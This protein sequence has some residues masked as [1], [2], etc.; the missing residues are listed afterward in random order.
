MTEDLLLNHR[1]IKNYLRKL[2]ST[3][4]DENNLRKLLYKLF[5]YD[6]NDI[7]ISIIKNEN[8][9]DLNSFPKIFNTV[10]RTDIINI[11]NNEVKSNYYEKIQI[12]DENDLDIY[13][14]N[15]NNLLEISLKTFRPV[16]KDN[17]KKLSEDINKIPFNKQKSYY[18]IYLKLYLKLHYFPD[19]DNF[20]KYIFNKYQKPIHKDIKIIFDNIEKSYKCVKD[21]IKIN[22]MNYNEIKY[23]IIKSTNISKRYLME[24]YNNI[25]TI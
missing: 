5:Y 15:E 19:I 7:P 9:I 14:I 21:Y 2:S 12:L 6:I 23:I 4:S 16:Y 24:Q 10:K 13:T 18:S 11:Y 20:I 8:D 1:I 25:A 17:W 3:I 22:N